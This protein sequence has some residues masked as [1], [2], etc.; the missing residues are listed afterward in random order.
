MKEN[1]DRMLRIEAIAHYEK[2]AVR[3]DIGESLGFAGQ[4]EANGVRL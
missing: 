3:K 1:S 4:S 2:N